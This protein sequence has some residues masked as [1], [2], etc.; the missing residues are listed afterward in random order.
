MKESSAVLNAMVQ[1][2]GIIG[3]TMF[4]ITW[5]IY[6]SM[7]FLIILIVA[8]TM[9]SAHYFTTDKLPNTKELNKYAAS[10]IF[11][12]MVGIMYMAT[13]YQIYILGYELFAGFAFAH[14]A[15][16]LASSIMRKEITE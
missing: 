14:S 13:S 15:I 8:Q 7:F 5:A 1:T 4:G 16:M 12:I 10:K 9:A 3:T 6:P 2:F 11:L